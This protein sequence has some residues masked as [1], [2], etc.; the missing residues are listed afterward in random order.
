MV[1]H[2]SPFGVYD[3]GVDRSVTAVTPSYY[4]LNTILSPSHGMVFRAAGLVSE[5]M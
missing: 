1:I 2:G 5:R 4:Q 3:V